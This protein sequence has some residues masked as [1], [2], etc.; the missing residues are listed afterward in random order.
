MQLRLAC[1]SSAGSC[2][3]T[4]ALTSSHCTAQEGPLCLQQHSHPHLQSVPFCP[5]KLANPCAI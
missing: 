1:C 2:I 5:Q 4:S 3:C